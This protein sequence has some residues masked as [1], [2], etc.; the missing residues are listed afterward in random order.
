MRS[1]EDFAADVRHLKAKW[2]NALKFTQPSA[3]KARESGGLLECR[4]NMK[5]LLRMKGPNR[6]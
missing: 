3:K 2:G 5:R 1:Q 4:V 6:V